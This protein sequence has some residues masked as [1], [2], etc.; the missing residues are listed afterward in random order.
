MNKKRTKSAE[1]KRFQRIFGP[2]DRVQT[3]GLM[4]P[5]CCP[6][7]FPLVYSHFRS[8]PLGFPY[9]LTLFEALFPRVPR[10]TVVIYVVK[11]HCGLRGSSA[12][13]TKPTLDGKRFAFQLFVSGRS[14]CNSAAEVMQGLSTRTAVQNLRDCNQRRRNKPHSISLSRMVP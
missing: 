2:S 1:I 10:L 6:N 5:N 4:V 14:D 3:C 7:F 12:R 13:I 9:S 8:F 11:T